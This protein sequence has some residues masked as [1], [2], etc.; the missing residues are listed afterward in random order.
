MGMKEIKHEAIHRKVMEIISTYKHEDYV[1]FTYDR[2]Y[3]EVQ[4]ELEYTEY[5]KSK[6]GNSLGVEE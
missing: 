5:M 6:D 2:M 3:D 1:Q 4:D